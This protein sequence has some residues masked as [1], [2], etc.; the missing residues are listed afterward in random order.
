M[1]AMSNLTTLIILKYVLIVLSYSQN[2][3]DPFNGT[4]L[5]I[6]TLNNILSMKYGKSSNDFEI[7]CTDF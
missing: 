4:Y 6:K 2:F 3:C 1:D 5:D 7:K